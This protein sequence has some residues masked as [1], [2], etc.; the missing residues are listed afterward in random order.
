MQIIQNKL[1][2]SVEANM[3]GQTIAYDVLYENGI[4]HYE[5]TKPEEKELDL[6]LQPEYYD[7]HTLDEFILKKAKL[8][9]NEITFKISGNERYWQCCNENATRFRKRRLRRCRG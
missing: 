2:G 3:I 4:A 5:Y 6:K 1:S 8:S 7:F 9:G